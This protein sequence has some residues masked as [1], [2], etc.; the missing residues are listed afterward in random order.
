MS[1]FLVLIAATLSRLVPHSLHLVSW[2]FTALAAGCSIRQVSTYHAFTSDFLG[3]AGGYLP[4]RCS[5]TGLERIHRE[6]DPLLMPTPGAL[7][8]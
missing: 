8:S 5:R 1:A 6:S 2:N 3:Q 4:I 7:V